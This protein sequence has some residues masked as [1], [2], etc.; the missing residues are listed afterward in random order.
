MFLTCA[1]LG[2]T[3]LIGFPSSTQS[4][5]PV[6]PKAE[7]I[8]Y[9][10]TF[11]GGSY[12]GVEIVE[13][14]SAKAGQIGLKEPHG[15]LV[16]RVVENSPA[17]KAGLQVND[18]IVGWND[19]RVLGV[20]PLIE[21]VHATPV[22]STVELN[23]IRDNASMNLS[24]T[25]EKRSGQIFS[26]MPHGSDSLMHLELESLGK[27]LE[28]M[29][30]D[31]SMQL[32]REMELELLGK[33]LK[34]IDPRTDSLM[35]REL[36]S[37]GSDLQKLGSQWDSMGVRMG[38]SGPCFERMVVLGR[39]RLG[40]ELQSLTPQLAKYFGAGMDAGALVSNVIE[41][42]AAAKGGLQAGDVITAIDG[43]K[44]GSPEEAMRI[45]REKPAGEIRLTILRDKR[46]RTIRVT[47]A[48]RNGSGPSQPSAAPEGGLPPRI[49]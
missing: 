19:I 10:R 48:E 21:L 17:A 20:E 11:C 46:E 38:R 34:A 43:K 26:F 1:M 13:V 16:V 8:C 29:K 5:A 37:L 27:K 22:G 14:D 45:I 36:E 31:S 33:Q 39:P 35:R 44:V 32:N 42:S 2:G 4:P 49:E 3:S 6:A 47:L 28:N 9:V 25:L 40:V 7:K 24:A 15:A 18:V 41:N 30:L 23:V 12:L